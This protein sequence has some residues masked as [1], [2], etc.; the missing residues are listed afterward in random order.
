MNL[1]RAGALLR[2]SATLRNFFRPTQFGQNGNG[3]NFQDFKRGL[4]VAMMSRATHSEGGE[5]KTMIQFPNPSIPQQNPLAPL[6]AESPEVASTYWGNAKA[7]SKAR[8]YVR[9]VD[10]N[11]QA[12]ARGGRKRSNARVWIREG[13]GNVEVNGKSWVDYFTRIDQRDK[14][15]RPLH[16]CG[17]TGKMDVTCVVRGGGQTGQAEAIRFCIARAIQNWDPSQ[18][19]TLKKDGLLTRDSRIVEMKKFGKKKARKSFQWVK[20]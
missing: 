19:K 6:S 1:Y 17:M 15:L 20:R 7:E 18:R 8:I 13:V 11:G 2:G 14:I 16:L 10:E 5:K 4:P 9:Q 12:T 3:D